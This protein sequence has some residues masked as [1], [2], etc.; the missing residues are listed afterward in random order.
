MRDI[1]DKKL[2]DLLVNFSVKLK[3]GE[4]CLINAVDVPLEFVEELVQAVYAAGGYPLVNISSIRLERAV[5]AGASR[6][7][8]AVFKDCDLFR[9]KQMDTFIGVRGPANSRETADLPEENNALYM[10]EYYKPVHGEQRIPHTRWV[11]LRYPTE[12]MA[13]AAGMSTIEFENYY[14]R[15]TTEVDYNLMAKA[16][17]PAVEFLQKADKVRITG[18]GTDLSFSIKGMPAIP[19][20]G[21]RNIP[22]GEIYS[23][24]GKDSVEGVI[25]YNTPSTYQGFTFTQVSFEFS[26]GKIIKAAANNTGKLEAILDIDQGSR[27]IGE[28]ALGCNPKITFPMD[29]TLFDEKIMGSFHFTPGNAYED[30]DNGNRSAVHWDL[31]VIQTPAYGGGEIWID[32]ELVRKDGVFVHEA[33][34]ALNPENLE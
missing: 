2:A 22:D 13:Y 19:C 14:Y 30:C 15:V 3:K 25:T 21:R 31:V 9:M 11:V 10:R 1:R 20:D 34:T 32:D 16:M 29:N 5:I 23:C 28:F 6:E 27:F 33:F 18:A 8:L 7:S 4:S 12:L 17:E 24:P 26:R